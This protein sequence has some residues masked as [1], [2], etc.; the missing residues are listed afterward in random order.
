MGLDE[1]IAKIKILAE[2][3]NLKDRLS[4]KHAIEVAENATGVVSKVLEEGLVPS[5]SLSLKIAEEKCSHL[6]GILYQEMQKLDR[7]DSQREKFNSLISDLQ[8]RLKS[9]TEAQE[10]LDLTSRELSQ[11]DLRRAE[12]A[13][14]TAETVMNNNFALPIVA[15][16]ISCAEQMIEKAKSSIETATL[17]H[18]ELRRMKEFEE[19]R[20]RLKKQKE[21]EEKERR[22]QIELAKRKELEESIEGLRYRLQLHKDQ[23]E[24]YKNDVRSTERSLKDAREKLSKGSLIASEVA[25]NMATTKV[26]QLDEMADVP[27]KS[28]NSSNGNSDECNILSST[29]KESQ[30]Q[31]VPWWFTVGAINRVSPEVHTRKSFTLGN[32]EHHQHQR[33]EEVKDE[34]LQLRR[35]IIDGSAQNTDEIVNQLDQLYKELKN[36]VTNSVDN[37]DGNKPISRRNSSNLMT[38]EIPSLKDSITVEIPSRKNSINLAPE[39]ENSSTTKH[40]IDSQDDDDD[41]NSSF[42]APEEDEKIIICDPGDFSDN[43]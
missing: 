39:L 32:T 29:T 11:D 40:S 16:E 36:L 10:L 33:K 1:R 5:S 31:A 43:L 9:L 17:R 6:E 42:G 3:R 25:A 28:S 19:Q 30:D 15:K 12:H 24:S 23:M 27:L 35:K 26:L 22:R 8:G 2:L 38:V 13:L 18:E 37:G 34:T 21:E 20:Q 4:I 41:E 7:E 14:I